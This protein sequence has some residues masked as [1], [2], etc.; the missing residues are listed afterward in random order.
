MKDQYRASLFLE[1]GNEKLAQNDLPGALSS[2]LQAEKLDNKNTYILNSL[3][4][5]YFAQ[6]QYNYAIDY[7]HRALKIDPN[8]SEAHNNLGQV[9]LSTRQYALAEKH[10]NFAIQD[11]TYRSPEKALTNMALLHQHKKDYK[12]SKEFYL[13]ALKINSEFCPAY[14]QYGQ[15]LIYMKDYEGASSILDRAVRI[16]LNNLEEA[17]YLSALSYY[18]LGKKDIS[19]AR[20]QEVIKLYPASEYADKARDLLRVVKQT[21]DQQQDKK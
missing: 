7:L 14:K 13:R 2:L 6:S 9:Y 8:F 21:S 18:Q 12:K 1:L 11:L 4:M 16:C 19:V 3:A 5:V 17:H 10:I 15:T 20:L